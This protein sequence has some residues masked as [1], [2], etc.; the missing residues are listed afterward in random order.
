[1]EDREGEY[2]SAKSKSD[3]KDF[4]QKIGTNLRRLRTQKGLSQENVADELGRKD[5]TAYGKIEQGNTALSFV[6]AVKVAKLF[7]VSLDQILN[8]EQDIP[9]VARDTFQEKYLTAQKNSV[10]MMVQLTGSD[11]DLQRQFELLT[12]IN[13][14]L[15]SQKK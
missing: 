14:L 10:S 11:E 3:V 4:N 7:K 2:K 13:T 12:N 6:D 1:M 9:F 15:A 8:P 5:Y